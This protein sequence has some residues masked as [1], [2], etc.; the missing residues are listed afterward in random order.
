MAQSVGAAN[1]ASGLQDAYLGLSPVIAITGRVQP[2][3][4]FR[5]AYQETLHG[6]L[7]APVTKFQACID[8]VEQL[9]FLLRQAF[10]EGTSGPPRLVHLDLID[11]LGRVIDSVT[12]KFFFNKPIL[13]ILL[14]FFQ[15]ILSHH[16]NLKKFHRDSFLL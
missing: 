12:K 3:A 2:I 15:N 16:M 13:T 6:P 5:N 11:N 9:P 4:R 8:T 7:F 10:R 1:L 14:E